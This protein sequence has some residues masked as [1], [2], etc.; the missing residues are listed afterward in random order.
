MCGSEDRNKSFVAVQPHDPPSKSI[1]DDR[2]TRRQPAGPLPKIVYLPCDIR[3]NLLA[4]R[5][6]TNGIEYVHHAALLP[7]RC[8]HPKT[9]PVRA[10]RSDGVL[11]LPRALSLVSLQL[12][13]ASIV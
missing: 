10:H 9:D 8:N 3:R 1:S 13:L 7:L 12:S 6:I 11:L 2:F 4:A 5:S